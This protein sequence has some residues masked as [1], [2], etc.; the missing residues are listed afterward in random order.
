M[1]V[2]FNIKNGHK[3]IKGCMVCNP[4]KFEIKLGEQI[5]EWNYINK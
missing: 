5:N 3:N 2:K 4:Y 1:N